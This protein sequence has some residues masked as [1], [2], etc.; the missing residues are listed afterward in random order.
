[1]SKNRSTIYWKPSQLRMVENYQKEYGGNWSQSVNGLI[2]HQFKVVKDQT[3]LIQ[4]QRKEIHTLHQELDR[5]GLDMA[6]PIEVHQYTSTPPEAPAKKPRKKS[7]A[8]IT[9]ASPEKA[10]TKTRPSGSGA[11]GSKWFVLGD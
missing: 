5:I 1:M 8:P 4:F 10:I 2:Q 9:K 3:E 6:M 7:A 11:G